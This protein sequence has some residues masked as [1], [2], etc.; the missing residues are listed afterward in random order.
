MKEL[1]RSGGP[2]RNQY[3]AMAQAVGEQAWSIPAFFF[4][5]R[6]YMG[7]VDAETTGAWLVDR[8]SQCRGKG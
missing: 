3:Q 8:M 2:V 1:E 4:C 6:L 7:W 5:K